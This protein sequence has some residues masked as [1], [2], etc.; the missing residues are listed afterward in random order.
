LDE[1]F[2]LE[3]SAPGHSLSQVIHQAL[4]FEQQPP[5][6][7]TLLHFWL[8]IVSSPVFGRLLSTVAVAGAIG[9]LWRLARDLE[10]RGPWVSLPFLAACCPFV[11]WAAADMRSYGLTLFLTAATTWCFARLWVVDKPPPTG[12]L[13]GY[14]GLTALSLLTF[15]YTGFLFAAQLLA[16]WLWGRRRKETLIAAGVIA[17]LLLPALPVIHR[18]FGMHIKGSFPPPP[19]GGAV[20]QAID[21]VWR[22][23]AIFFDTFLFTDSKDTPWL[24]PTLLLLIA[25][26]VASRIR[27][28]RVRWHREATMLALTGFLPFI[29]L[30]TFDNT[31]FALVS[32][33]HRGIIILPLLAAAALA[34]DRIPDASFRTPVGLILSCLMAWFGL[35]FVRS[36]RPIQDYQTAARYVTQH[37]GAEEPIFFFDNVGVLAFKHYYRGSNVMLGLPRDYT[38]EQWSNEVRA[39][40]SSE[41]LRSRIDSLV[42]A[43]GDFWIV[44]RKQMGRFVRPEILEA[45]RK[46]EVESLDSLRVSGL[47]VYHLRRR[48]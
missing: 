30:E 1:A 2:S 33:R 12:L 21:V 26:L 4:W 34:V 3:T 47:G 28:G 37:E 17:A 20:F 7:F 46:N 11:L 38:L 24:R 5:L 29:V 15:Y 40:E 42:P 36:D 31:S 14:I 19:E 44:E 18:Q 13:P 32:D 39:L 6:Y 8:S 22:T 35:S 45:F 25:V 48:D 27:L 23:V 16:G 9:I 41:Q 10:L 43:G